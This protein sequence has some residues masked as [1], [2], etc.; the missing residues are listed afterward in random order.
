[1]S[2]TV[3]ITE[4]RARLSQLVREATNADIVVM[5]HGQPAAVLISV[6]RYQSLLKEMEDLRDRLSVH[7]R[8]HLTTPLSK[9]VTDWAE[10]DEREIHPDKGLH[11]RQ[12]A[13]VSS[14]LLRRAQE[15]PEQ[16]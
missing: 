10:S 1:M 2:I 8:E 6:A 12:A 5:N 14:E 11:G 7:E 16:A 3:P 4:A 9:L 13:E 15:R